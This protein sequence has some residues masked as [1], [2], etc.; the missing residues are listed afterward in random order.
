MKEVSAQAGR[1][2]F[3]KGWYYR[4]YYQTLGEHSFINPRF[5]GV[6]AWVVG[7]EKTPLQ[8]NKLRV[9]KAFAKENPPR[10]FREKIKL[11][12]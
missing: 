9:F 4:R 10:V 8:F 11:C 3:Y 1:I 6:K 12:K 5:L 2:E 7:T